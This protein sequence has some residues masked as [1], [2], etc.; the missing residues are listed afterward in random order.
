MQTAFELG[1]SSSTDCGCCHFSTDSD[2]GLYGC[3]DRSTVLTL[4]EQE[5]LEQ[6]RATGERAREI[7]KKLRQ[8]TLEG[9]LES[10]SQDGFFE[11]L[12]NLRNM[13]IA[14][15]EERITAADERMRLLGH[16]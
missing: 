14:L 4:R 3:S 12:E 9:R 2:E 1:T 8:S 10:S 5:V 7:K 6:I 13:R 11:E 16:L 15:E